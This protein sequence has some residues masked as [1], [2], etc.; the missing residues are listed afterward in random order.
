M[1]GGYVQPVQDFSV[2]QG[3]RN[4]EGLIDDFV[5]H[6]T[7][8]GLFLQYRQ[9]F[10]DPVQQQPRFLNTF[11]PAFELFIPQAHFGIDRAQQ[12]VQVFQRTIQ[13]FRDLNRKTLKSP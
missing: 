8:P 2:G 13:F 9:R 6:L 7:V 5:H 11:K 1:P 3:F 4:D 10:I 12:S